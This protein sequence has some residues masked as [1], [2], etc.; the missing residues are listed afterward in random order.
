[1]SCLNNNNRFVV[2]GG[3]DL[4]CRLIVEILPDET[5]KTLGMLKSNV[6]WTASL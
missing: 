6:A 4:T 3:G 2:G 1:M 5:Y